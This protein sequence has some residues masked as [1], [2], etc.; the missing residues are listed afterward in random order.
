[1]TTVLTV[2]GGV[3]LFAAGLTAG[4]LIA[5]RFVVDIIDYASNQETE[6]QE[7]DP[8]FK[9]PEVNLSSKEQA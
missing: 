5:H 9:C 2:I 3:G 4:V 6:A 1:M 8:D 7:D